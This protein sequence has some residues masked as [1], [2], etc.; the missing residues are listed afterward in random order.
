M[1]TSSHF[2]FAGKGWM[3]LI[4][5]FLCAVKCSGAFYNGAVSQKVTE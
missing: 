3:S 2:Y 1:G 4:K 5:D